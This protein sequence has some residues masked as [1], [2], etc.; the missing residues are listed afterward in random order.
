M[1][2]H[3]SCGTTKSGWATCRSVSPAWPSCPPL[4]LPD[5]PRR[6]R[7]ADFFFNPSLDGGVE[8]FVRC[9]APSGAGL[10]HQGLEL[11][12][13]PVLRSQQLLDF[14]RDD[15]PADSR[16]RRPPSLTI[17]L[18]GSVSTNLWQFGLTTGWELRNFL[19]TLSFL[20]LSVGAHGQHLA[21]VLDL[22]APRLPRPYH[23]PARIQSFQAVAAPFPGDSVLPSDPLA[24]RSRRPNRL[25][26]KVCSRPGPRGATRPGSERPDD[27]KKHPS[28]TLVS[29]KEKSTQNRRP[30]SEPPPLPGLEQPRAGHPSGA[31]V[32]ISR[33]SPW[34]RG[35]SPRITK[36]KAARLYLGA[37]VVWAASLCSK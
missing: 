4:V 9:P 11:R 8:L 28:T 18:P 13:Q 26:S 29:P 17:S 7:G 36:L 14:G 19:S 10:G 31:L 2:A 15:H 24:P 21:C 3:A 35:S 22:V 20:R 25:G 32:I 33:T 30:Q 27:L 16:I 6:L 5:L 23:F 12:D 34:I 37:A 1:P